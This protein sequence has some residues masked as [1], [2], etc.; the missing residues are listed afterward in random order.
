MNHGWAA[1]L[2]ILT[3]LC[4]AALAF[5]LPKGGRWLALGSAVVTGG[6]LVVLTRAVIVGG[7]QTQQVGGWGAPLGIDL[8]ADGL[9]VLMLIIT[10][11]VS[12]VV[13]LYSRDYFGSDHDDKA[14][15]RERYFW[16][17]LLFLGAAL[18]ALFLSADI[19]NLYVTLELLGFSAVALVAL[20]GERP[21][22]E[23]AMRYLLVSL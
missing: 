9:A 18:N 8:R 5:L 22:L 16:P 14:P 10:A 13:T 19:F 7:T 1:A 15:H 3:P 20:A 21:A 17:L 6:S 11:V 12:A 23:A 2:L 4:A